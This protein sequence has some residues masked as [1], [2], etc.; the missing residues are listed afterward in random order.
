MVNYWN[1]QANHP[2]GSQQHT[3]IETE[4]ER[5]DIHTKSFHAIF[6]NR[7]RETEWTYKGRAKQQKTLGRGEAKAPL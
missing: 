7:D 3:Q 4:R 5:V 6:S 2:H 1:W